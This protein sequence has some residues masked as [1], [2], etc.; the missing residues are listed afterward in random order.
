MSRTDKA[1]L[2]VAK[3]VKY[4]FESDSP[5]A[6]TIVSKNQIVDWLAVNHDKHYRRALEEAFM[7]MVED[8]VFEPLSNNPYFQDTGKYWV[9]RRH[10]IFRR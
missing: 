3:L 5:G 9:N 8:N 7:E 1:R 6:R 4:M 10:E 2:Q